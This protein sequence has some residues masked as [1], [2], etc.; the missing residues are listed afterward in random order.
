MCSHTV[1]IGLEE[2]RTNT[3]FTSAS[4][5]ETEVFS[6]LCVVTLVFTKSTCLRCCAHNLNGIGEKLQ[7]MNTIIVLLRQ[8]EDL[9]RSHQRFV[10]L[11]LVVVLNIF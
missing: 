7:F 5:P 6:L 8:W 9:L 3:S 4:Y 2:D 11:S 10:K 1:G